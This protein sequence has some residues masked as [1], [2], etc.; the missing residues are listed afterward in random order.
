M[1]LKI[2]NKISQHFKRGYG[3]GLGDLGWVGMSEPEPKLSPSL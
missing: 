1:I 3:M 2:H